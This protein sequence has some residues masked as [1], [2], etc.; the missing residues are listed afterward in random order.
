MIELITQVE[1]KKQREDTTRRLCKKKKRDV[2]VDE[3]Q[4][5]V[6]IETS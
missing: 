6:L 3:N 4:Y 5:Q 2:E 1:K